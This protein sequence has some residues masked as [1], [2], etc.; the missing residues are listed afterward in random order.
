MNLS[1]DKSTFNIIKWQEENSSF[2]DFFHQMMKY[3]RSGNIA[4]L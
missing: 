1:Y 3:T 2:H 4:D